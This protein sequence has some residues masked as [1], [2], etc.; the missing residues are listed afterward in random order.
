MFLKLRSLQKYHFYVPSHVPK[1]QTLLLRANI[2]E[3]D[4]SL[5]AN[6]L[7]RNMRCIPNQTGKYLWMTEY[8]EFF[9]SGS[10]FRIR[11][12]ISNLDT[13]LYSESG[14]AFR[15]RIRICIKNPDMY[16]ESG[17]VF[18]IRICI[19]NPNLYSEF[20]SV[21]RI[22][23][24]IQNSDLYSDSRS[25]IVIRIRI[26]ICIQNPDVALSFS[27]G[28]GSVKNDPDLEHYFHVKN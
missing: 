27:P 20:G 2:L 18:R 26:R 28:S 9:R 4:C 25:G 1:S 15:I 11:I 16:S 23:I 3:F 8:L 14:T 17:Y 19:Q 6:T 24:C 5:F 7:K 10:P 13:D 12:G 21:F 22:R